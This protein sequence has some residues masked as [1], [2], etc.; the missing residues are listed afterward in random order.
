MALK[1][2][3]DVLALG[4]SF[5]GRTLLALQEQVRQEHGYQ[6]VFGKRAG[7]GTAIPTGSKPGGDGC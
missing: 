7:S 4:D 1:F 2:N 3:G 6:I 5:A